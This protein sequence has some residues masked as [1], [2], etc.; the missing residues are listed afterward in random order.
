MTVYKKSCSVPGAGGSSL[1]FSDIIGIIFLALIGL[2]VVVYGA[3]VAVL[4][5]KFQKEGEERTPFLPETVALIRGGA[6]FIVSTARGL[7]RRGEYSS[8]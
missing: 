4:T 2:F 3:T 7:T 6:L 8:V 5:F 1:G